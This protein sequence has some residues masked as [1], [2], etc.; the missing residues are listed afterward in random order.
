MTIGPPP[1]PAQRKLF[2]KSFLYNLS[3][4]FMGTMVFFIIV[5]IFSKFFHMA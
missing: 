3:K 1:E 4:I 5:L 2:A